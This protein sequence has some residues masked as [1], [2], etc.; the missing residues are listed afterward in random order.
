MAL[1]QII[2]RGILKKTYLS[3]MITLDELKQFK[4]IVDDMISEYEQKGYDDNYVK[5]ANIIAKSAFIACNRKKKTPVIYGKNLYLI[6]N[7][8]LNILK[9]GITDDVYKRYRTIRN[10]D[11]FNEYELLFSIKNKSE[12]ESI[13]HEKYNDLRLF[14][15]WFENSEEIVDEF[16]IL[17]NE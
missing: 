15:E 5:K 2:G 9:I 16:K 7:V 4:L 13:L 11:I 10:Q 3:E 8:T 17:S 14:G 12:Y 6:Q 1:Y